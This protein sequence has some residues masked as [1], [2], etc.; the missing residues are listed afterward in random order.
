MLIFGLIIG[1]VMTL[2]VYVSY[3][4]IIAY[5]VWMAVDAAKQDRFWWVVIIFGVPIIG[6]VAYYFT[7][8]KH[9]YAVA[10]THHI[11]ESETEIEHETSHKKHAHEDGKE[12]KVVAL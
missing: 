1:A 12:P 3:I 6:S 10:P 5:T 4:I 11:H 9:V 2:I 7:E 8:K